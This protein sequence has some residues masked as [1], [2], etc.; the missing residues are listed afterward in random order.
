MV[1]QRTSEL[2]KSN[3]LLENR[4]RKITRQ[5]EEIHTKHKE[6]TEK[7]NM[8]LEQNRELEMHRNNLEKLIN[9]RTGELVKAKEKAEES[10]Q[11]KS[12]F[13]ANMS[14]EI[15]TPL[16]AI[17]GFSELIDDDTITREDKSLFINQINKN[18]EALLLLIDDILDLSYIEAGQIQLNNTPFDVNCFLEEII[19]IF[20]STQTPENVRVI[21][22]NNEI[23]NQLQLSSDAHRVRQ[24]LLN[25]ISN[26]IKFT[27][28]GSITLGLEHKNN[29]LLFTVKDTGIGI[30]KEHLPVI[31]DRFRKIENNA[32]KIYRGSGLG[33]SISKKLAKL[34]HAN[35]W[36]DSEVGIGSTFYLSF[37]TTR[38]STAA[39][40]Q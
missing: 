19:A 23:T 12:A 21:L 36:V 39:S 2:R 26:A 25:L 18:T 40:L 34:L 11:L 8:I 7:N 3:L 10:D 16:N 28:K 22:N 9:E 27:E 31:F 33:L 6:V 29:Q 38:V 20:Q 1:E 4:N 15:R 13:L 35:L 5:K 14:H 30:A 32:T 37:S 24:I 17:I